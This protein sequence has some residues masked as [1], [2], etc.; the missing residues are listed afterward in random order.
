MFGMKE[1]GNNVKV[2]RNINNIDNAT[3]RG[4]RQAF[5]QVGWDWKRPAQRQILSKKKSGRTY[6]V[7]RGK[8][9]R[10]HTASAPGES[11]A[12]LSG[13]YRR[14]IGFKIQGSMKLIFGA[15]GTG[16]PYAPFLEEGTKNMKP[17][18]GLKN[19]IKANERNTRQHFINNLN[20]NLTIAR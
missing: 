7:R 10:R 6:L 2:F 3:R 9:R 1:S 12:N 19:S 4:L 14:S 16:V 15:G 13:A 20:K 18:P 5:F 11:P 8:T 17:R